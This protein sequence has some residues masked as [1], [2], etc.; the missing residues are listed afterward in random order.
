MQK[1]K[2]D[3]YKYC[4][5][6]IYNTKYVFHCN[7]PNMEAIRKYFKEHNIKKMEG[8]IGFG[9]KFSKVPKNKTTPKWC[10][11]NLNQHCTGATI[12]A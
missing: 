5:S 8:F 2:Y 3:N 6:Y 10:P 9:E 7:H 12:E 11:E 1:C 4:R